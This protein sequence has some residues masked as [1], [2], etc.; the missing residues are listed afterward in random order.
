MVA[1]MATV[2]GPSAVEATLAMAAETEGS[3]EYWVVAAAS[4]VVAA[5]RE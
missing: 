2:A 1:L 4:S 3:E 5:R